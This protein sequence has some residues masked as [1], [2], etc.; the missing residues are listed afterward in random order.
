M[1]RATSTPAAGTSAI[2][3]MVLRALES[4]RARLASALRSETAQVLA[5]VLVGLAAAT[6]SDDLAEVRAMLEDLRSAVRLDLERVQAQA[7]QIRPSLL[8]DFGLA[9]AVRSLSENLAVKSGTSLTVAVDDEPA[10]LEPA[11][12]ALVF[13][14]VEEAVRNALRHSQADHIG[15]SLLRTAQELRFEI[16]DDGH[17]FDL[18]PTHDAS[19]ETFGLALMQAQARALGGSLEIVSRPGAGTRVLL[20]IP[21]GDTTNG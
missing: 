8:D 21:Q 20:R 12:E 6:Q 19:S 16:E 9:A 14:T 4:E 11:E 5:T 7:S 2:E 15:V 10:T 18:A 3:A 17:G 13:R 1:K